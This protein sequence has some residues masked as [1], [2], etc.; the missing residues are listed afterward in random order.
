MFT[1]EGRTKTRRRLR[2]WPQ[3]DVAYVLMGQYRVTTDRMGPGDLILGGPE[4]YETARAACLAAQDSR[5]M[6][7]FVAKL[8]SS[9]NVD[10][11]EYT[12]PTV[13]SNLDHSDDLWGGGPWD[14]DPGAGTL[15]T[16]TNP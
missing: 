12:A 13:G 8:Q 2:F 1:L 7:E 14:R 5:R 15:V 4:H 6:A 9:I 10:Q 3:P 16:Y 11:T